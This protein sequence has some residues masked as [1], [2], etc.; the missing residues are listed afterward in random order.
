[1]GAYESVNEGHQSNSSDQKSDAVL[2]TGV[3]VFHA[4]PQEIAEAERLIAALPTIK[5]VPAWYAEGRYNFLR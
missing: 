5:E 3:Q 1:M 4:I 2:D